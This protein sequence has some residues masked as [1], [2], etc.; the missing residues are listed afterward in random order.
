[1]SLMTAQGSHQE[2]RERI[3][4][5]D[6]VRGFALVGVGLVHMFEQFLGAGTPKDNQSGEVAAS[7]FNLDSLIEGLNQ[8]LC[9]GKFYIL[10]SFLFGLSLFIQMDRAAEQGRPFMGRFVWRLILLAGFGFL[11]HFFYRADILLVYA[12]LGLFTL[13]WVRLPSWALIIWAVVLF[14]GGGRILV[15]LLSGGESLFGGLPLDPEAP[16][17]RDYYKVIKEG[18]LL[19]VF[20]INAV[21]GIRSSFDFVFGLFGRAYVTLGLFFVGVV[22]GRSGF[23]RDLEAKKKWLNRA[24]PISFVSA[25]IVLAASIGLAIALF[26]TEPFTRLEDWRIVALLSFYDVFNLMLAA[27]YLLVFLRLYQT[28]W[29]QSVLNVFVPYGRTALSSYLL[30]ALVGTWFYYGWGLGNLGEL[31]AR[32]RLVAGLVLI[33]LQLGLS[34]LWM[35]YFLYG[36][37]EWVWR[38]LT[39]WKLF[40]LF[41]PRHEVTRD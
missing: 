3:T 17:L 12:I 16:E 1:M 5:I 15:F 7:G 14:L 37:M 13:F 36:P 21:G 11:H 27:F 32:Y 2:Q 33:V 19:D 18:T 23:F 34:A 8:L 41:R 30:Q 25:V 29:G 22:L 9:V 28:S 26:R 40:P 6:A 10:F 24:I 35:R 4:V 39:Q 20:M 31:D 38:A